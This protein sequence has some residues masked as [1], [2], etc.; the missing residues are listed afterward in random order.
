VQEAPREPAIGVRERMLLGLVLAVGVGLRVNAVAHSAVEHFDEGVYASNLYF[1]PPAFAY[2][3]QR[4]YAP[5]LLPALIEAGMIVGLPANL[6]ALMPSFLAGCGTIVAVWWLGRAWFGPAA[7]L[8]A[9][10]L[11]ALSHFHIVYSAAALTDALLGLWLV[12]AV[13]AMA[14]LL[15]VGDTRWA[16]AAGLYTGLAWWT[17]YNGWLPLAIEAAALPVLWLLLRPP[18]GVWRKWLACFAVTALVAGLVWSPYLFVLREHGGYGPIAENH[19]KYV[20]GLAGWLDAASRQ[21]ANFFVI[22]GGWSGAAIIAACVVAMLAPKDTA[23]VAGQVQPRRAVGIALVAV[24][25]FGLF[26]ATPFYWAYPRLLLP[27]LLATW[28]LAGLWL[29]WLQLARGPRP[30]AGV[31]GVLLACGALGGTG[32]LWTARASVGGD[33]RRSL[34]SIARKLRGDLDAA[35]APPRSATSP[36]T[37]AVYV[38]GEPAILF[39][40]AAAGERIVAPAQQITGT[41]AALEGKL[42]PTFL[43]AGP[44]ADRDPQIREQL[45]A[46]GRWKLVQSYEYAPSKLVWLDL[47]DPRK[48]ALEEAADE[49]AFRVYEIQP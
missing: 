32:W 31:I 44:H 38:L 39:Q 49:H 3:M 30:A 10:A 7:G 43:V 23:Y 34:V 33:E 28:L 2:P 29:G 21:V 27:W 26:V 11:V 17:K 20:V 13:D 37:R 14:R 6:A 42:L 41:S 9:A 4:F 40:L 24:W 16:I 19:A 48:P 5:P 47:H 36:P 22:D 46:G 45:A 35:S 1:G 15:V 12:L 25:W 8:A 18:R